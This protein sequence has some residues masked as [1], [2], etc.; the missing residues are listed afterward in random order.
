MRPEWRTGMARSTLALGVWVSA[1]GMLLCTGGDA[2]WAQQTGS[3]RPSPP[4]STAIVYDK[5][6]RRLFWDDNG[7]IVGR[8]SFSTGRYIAE[9]PGRQRVEKR[10]CDPPPPGEAPRNLAIVYWRKGRGE[11]SRKGPKIIQGPTATGVISRHGLQSTRT[12]EFASD[13]SPQSNF[14]ASGEPD[15]MP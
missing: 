12:G 10:K 2:A 6:G 8:Y 11:N 1:G 9:L 3:W 5:K 13:G 14:T 7:Q 4:N 15:Q